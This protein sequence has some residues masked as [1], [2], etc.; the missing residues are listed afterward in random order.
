MAAKTPSTVNRYSLGDKTLIEATFADIDDLDT[1]ASGLGTA[2]IGYWINGTDAPT[3]TANAVLSVSNS[4]GTF[5][6]HSGE[7]NRTGILYIT[8]D[9]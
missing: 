3:T 5:T 4:S 2:V 8:G 7:A 6:F 9:F 1:Y